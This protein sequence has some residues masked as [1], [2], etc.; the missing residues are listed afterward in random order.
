M[1]VQFIEIECLF[2]NNLSSFFAES[3]LNILVPWKFEKVRKYKE[4]KIKV[5]KICTLKLKIT[6]S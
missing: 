6:K 1:L 2:K 5:L 4:K 3:V